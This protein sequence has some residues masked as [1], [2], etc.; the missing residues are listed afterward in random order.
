MM[1]ASLAKMA[2]TQAVDRLGGQHVQ[3][4]YVG[5]YGQFVVT[6]SIAPEQRPQARI[7]SLGQEDAGG[8]GLPVGIDEQHPHAAAGGQHIGQIHGGGG[9]PYPAFPINN[10]KCSHDD[11]S[12]QFFGII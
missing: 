4:L 2:E 9:L 8:V 1:M 5:M 10:G 12:S 11:N 3:P 7:F 6:D